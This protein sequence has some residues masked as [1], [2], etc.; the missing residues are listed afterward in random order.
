M[1]V[2]F[3]LYNLRKSKN[4]KA[5]WIQ[6]IIMSLWSDSSPVA[7]NIKN[8]RNK[9]PQQMKKAILNCSTC[10]LFLQRCVVFTPQNKQT[11]NSSLLESTLFIIL[12]STKILFITANGWIPACVP[13]ELNFCSSVLAHPQY[14]YLCRSGVY[15]Q[16]CY[17]K[18]IFVLENPIEM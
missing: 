13:W 2:N 4:D 18:R 15:P 11:S 3:Y 10:F 12:Q 1:S 6:W 14:T 7:L 17:L 8:S 16:L 9:Q 5:T